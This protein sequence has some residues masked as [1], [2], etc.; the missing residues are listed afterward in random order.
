MQVH[1]PCHR[2]HTL[3]RPR[4]DTKH[5]RIV[6]RGRSLWKFA[7]TPPDEQKAT[8]ATPLPKRIAARKLKLQAEKQAIKQS[9]RANS[10]PA[11]VL[12]MVIP[13]APPSL[14]PHLRSNVHREVVCCDLSVKSPRKNRQR[15]SA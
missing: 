1:I 13:P 12:Q 11:A 5:A 4:L 7:S 14:P 8:L 6:E 10:A 2:L 15:I 9:D 3:E